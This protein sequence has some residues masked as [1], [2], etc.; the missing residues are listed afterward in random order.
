VVTCKIK[1]FCNQGLRYM[2]CQKALALRLSGFGFF[3][4]YINCHSLGLEVCI[5]SKHQNHSIEGWYLTNDSSLALSYALKVNFTNS[6]L[7]SS[8]L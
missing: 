5:W 3:L 7:L 6:D 2:I 4:H 8:A 1:H